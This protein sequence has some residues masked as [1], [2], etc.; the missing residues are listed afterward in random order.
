MQDK[1]QEV[2]KSYLA[3]CTPDIF[4]FDDKH[5]LAYR[6]QIDDARVSNDIKPTG[7]DIMNAIKALDTGEIIQEQKMASGCNIKWK[8]GNNP[9]YFIPK[10]KLK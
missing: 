7:K 4:L 10:T 8:E 6:G 3:S 5:K 9:S 2:A 1:T